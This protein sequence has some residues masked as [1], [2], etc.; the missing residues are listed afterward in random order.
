MV[1]VPTKA[2]PKPS[3]F[4]GHATTP[5]NPVPIPTPVRAS[6]ARKGK[7]VTPSDIFKMQILSMNRRNVGR[8]GLKGQVI[9]P[10]SSCSARPTKSAHIIMLDAA[11]PKS[12]AKSKARPSESEPKE[13]LDSDEWTLES[14]RFLC[15]LAVH[16]NGGLLSFWTS[17]L[18]GKPLAILLEMKVDVGRGHIHL[19]PNY[20][21][22][23]GATAVLSFFS[24]LDSRSMG[25][26]SLRDFY[27]FGMSACQ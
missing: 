17:M 16:S 23:T 26:P 21:F 15:T 10:P 1:V 18:T 22:L 20:S 14:S 27:G 12:K 2:Q 25:V 3:K 6:L 5:M 13:H 4:L 11:K 9:A 19:Q 24:I 7:L 8:T